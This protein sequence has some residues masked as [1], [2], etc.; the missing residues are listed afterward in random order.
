MDRLFSRV[1]FPSGRGNWRLVVRSSRTRYGPVAAPNDGSVS[2]LNDGPAAALD[3]G[4][5]AALDAGPVAARIS[6]I[7]PMVA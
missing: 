5:V 4:P 1:L 2:A 6:R 7:G 3:D